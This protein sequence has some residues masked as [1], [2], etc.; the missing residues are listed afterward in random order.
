MS[1]AT[2]WQTV[3]NVNSIVNNLQG[4]DRILFAKGGSWVDA[5]IGNVYNFNTTGANPIVFDSYDPTWGGIAKPILTEAR[6][7]INLF[8]FTDG[9]NADHDEGYVVQNL[10]LRGGGTGMW[11]IFAYNDADNI[12]I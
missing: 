2:A 10:D 4:G 9:G 12:M 11:G 1:A 7:G 3:A 8:K 6:T 5:S